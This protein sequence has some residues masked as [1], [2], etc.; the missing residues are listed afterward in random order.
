MKLMQY[1]LAAIATIATVAIASTAVNAHGTQTGSCLDPKSTDSFEASFTR[2]TGTIKTADGKALCG[3]AQLFLQSFKLPDTWDGKGWNRTAIP[4]T[5]HASIGFTVPGGQ[6]NYTKT[7]TISV[8]DA[9]YATQLDF[10][11]APEVPA[12]I[13]YHDGEDREILGQIFKAT[14]K[15]ETT[16]TIKVCELA[17]KK[18][19]TINEKD[20]DAKKHSK[21]LDDCCK[22]EPKKIEVCDLTSKKIITINEKDFDSKKHSKTLSKCDTPKT[23]KV[24]ELATKKIVTINEKDFDA[25]K[26]SKSLGKCD[27][28]KTIEVCELATKKTITIDEKDFDSNKH[29]RTVSDCDTVPPVTP[30][31]LPKTGAAGTFASILG[32]GSLVASSYYYVVSRRLRA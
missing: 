11:L 12:I 21:N 20:F 9:C 23:I 3:D 24:C 6:K 31:E 5:K 14:G 2:G 15:C 1:A 27:T 17:T 28:P 4:Q 30:P 32:L 7:F 8:P 29:S 19:I 25:K 13:N 10:Y 22:E 16:K 26:H 18:E